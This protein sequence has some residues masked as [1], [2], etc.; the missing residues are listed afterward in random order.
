MRLASWL[1]KFA[2]SIGGV[3]FLTLFCVFIVQIGARFGFNQPL[4]WTDE[5]A[6]ILYIWVILWAA[7]FVVPA[8]EHVVF[9]LVWNSVGHRTRQVMAITG[10]LLVGGLALAGLPA[11]WDYVHFMQREGTPV[12]EIPLMWVYLPLVLLM[13]ALVVRCAWAIWQAARGI[14]LA[15]GD[16]QL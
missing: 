5:A 15:H 3:L 9:D 2:N 1:Q 13:A 10:N 6:V 16:L 7:A 12:L 11:T 14:G 8:R 4:P